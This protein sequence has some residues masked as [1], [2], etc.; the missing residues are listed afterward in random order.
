MHKPLSPFRVIPLACLLAAGA[1][2]ADISDTI[3]PF[4]QLAYSYDDNLLRLPEN[5]P[6]D[7]QRSDRSTQAIAGFLLDRPIGRQKLTGQ[8]KLSRV[9]FDHYDQL[10]YNGKDFS[11]DWAWALGNHLDGNI[12]GSYAQ[13]LTPFNDFHSDDRN[14]RTQR[15]EYINGGW[16]FHPS[17]RVRAGFQRYKYN[18]ELPAQSINDRTEDLSEAGIDYLAASGSKVGIVLRRLKGNYLNERRLGTAFLD[19]GYTQDELK[20]NVSWLYSDI[21]QLTV[22]AGYA[23]RKHDQ[24]TER[25]ASGANGRVTLTWKPRVKLRFQADAW[26]EFSAVESTFISNSLN[27]GGSV[28]GNWEITS[29]VSANAAFRR[30]KRR[31]EPLGNVVFTG[32]DSDSTRNT[33]A[34]LQYMPTR[35]IQLNLSGFHERRSGAPLVGT[36]SFKAKGVSVSATAQF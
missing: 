29:K 35:N 5:T 28:A 7:F 3:K 14:L 21:T 20:A 8:A 26:R 12:G 31:F 23:K 9:T 15:R 34:G 11:L 33:S 36:G 22:L 30:E 24:F 6:P 4:V 19:E 10:D 25:D 16:R 17:W 18:Y 27:R 13:T 2:H 1:A 32:G